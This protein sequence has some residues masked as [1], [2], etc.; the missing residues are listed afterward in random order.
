[1]VEWWSV[2]ECILGVVGRGKEEGVASLRWSSPAAGWRSKLDHPLHLGAGEL[3]HL[4]TGLAAAAA[5]LAAAD[6]ADDEQDQSDDRDDDHCNEEA[7][8]HAHART[9]QITG[10]F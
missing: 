1:M 2:S 9:D 7:S 8:G 10:G 4:C 3:C 6:D 5:V